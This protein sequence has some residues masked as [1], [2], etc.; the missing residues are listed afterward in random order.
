MS[1][2][3]AFRNK[4]AE[5]AAQLATARNET[6]EAR[7]NLKKAEA[8]EEDRYRY[9]RDMVA[10]LNKWEGEEKNCKH[11]LVTDVSGR[12]IGFDTQCTKCGWFQ[13]PFPVY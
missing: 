9:W 13:N 11:K 8:T 12:G 1:E 4:V 5:V 7:S 3:E 2:L 6:M 10:A